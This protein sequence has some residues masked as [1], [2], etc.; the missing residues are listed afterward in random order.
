MSNINYR[1]FEAKFR[2][3]MPKT[4]EKIDYKKADNSK[5]PGRKTKLF[6]LTIYPIVNQF[7]SSIKFKIQICLKIQLLDVS[8][9][10]K[11]KLMKGYL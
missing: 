5:T 6:K 2:H 4:N 8:K 11:F 3:K 1:R 7:Y 10:L 9:G